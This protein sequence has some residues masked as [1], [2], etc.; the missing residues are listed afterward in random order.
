MLGYWRTV[1]VFLNLPA[2]AL[3]ARD[4]LSHPRGVGRQT[5][6]RACGHKGLWKLGERGGKFG[7]I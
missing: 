5:L 4:R 3:L 1:G 2:K 6:V 7:P